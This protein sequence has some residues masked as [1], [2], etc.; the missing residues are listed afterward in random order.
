MRQRR[1]SDGSEV[2]FSRRARWSIRWVGL[3]LL[4]ATSLPS[5]VVGQPAEIPAPPDS[6]AIE[7]ARGVVCKMPNA[8]QR[9]S[10]ARLMTAV[11]PAASDGALLDV[12]PGTDLPEDA[13]P[14]ARPDLYGAAAW[15][16]ATYCRC[17]PELCVRT[18]T[19]P[20]PADDPDPV[21][22]DERGKPPGAAP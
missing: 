1:R 4:L 18:S 17:W 2:R 22:S 15:L 10:L 21:S 5:C 7:A 3:T 8:P 11:L 14:P 9:D 19:P 20:G 16:S 13:V 12:M 6:A